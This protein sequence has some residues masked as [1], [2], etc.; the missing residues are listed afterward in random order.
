MKWIKRILLALLAII[1]VAVFMNYRKLNII[2]GYTAKNMASAVF[3]AER[4]AKSVNEN[5]HQVPLI[6]LAETNVEEKEQAA[7][8]NVF[9]FGERTAAYR[10][11][12][13]SV[14][15]VEGYE[16]E[17]SN[18]KPNRNQL[19]NKL[20]FPYGNT[21]VQDTVFAN[22][23]YNRIEKALD[24]AFSHQDSIRT[25][26]AIVVYKDHILGE[27]YVEGFDENTPILG[28]SMTKSVLATLYG[29]LEKQRGLQMSESPGVK[30]WGDELRKKITFHDLLQMESGL[31]WEEDYSGISDVTKMLFFESDMSRIA[32][33]KE[34]IAAP[35]ELWNYSSGTS[36]LLSNILRTKFD[37]YQ[38]YLD[39][40]YS[41]LIDKMGM[42][43]MLLETDLS[44]NFVGSSYGWAG[45][46]DWAKFGL[47]Y[48]HK[49]NWNGTQ[50]FNPEWADYVATPN[51]KSDGE[52]G[53]HFWLNANG[54]YP[55][56]PRD[57]YGANGHL[58]QYIF[59][60]PSK[61]LVVVRTGLAENPKFDINAFLAE[62]VE[63]IE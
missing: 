16:S 59:I 24:S 14:L 52:Y 50:V 47:L 28:W 57:L 13:G 32:K 29:I 6:A 35:G 62:I 12:L 8:S 15:L 30:N 53:A 11:G 58:G 3:Y 1:I 23:D 43:T 18:E 51:R 44:G 45:T 61:E 49:G 5:D 63:A 48:L 9:G 21:G 31:E 34:A 46:R 25:R 10:E 60:I 17:H 37:S 19:E 55:D 2:S 33:Q 26:T 36:N 38:E 20:A 27:R 7:S 42:H 54:K 40:P 4:T 22:V 41:Q 56:V 39:F